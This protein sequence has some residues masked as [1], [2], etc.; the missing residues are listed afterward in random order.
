MIHVATFKGLLLNIVCGGVAVDLDIDLDLHQ[1]PFARYNYNN[2][3]K[4]NKT[5]RLMQIIFP[6]LYIVLIMVKRL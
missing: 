3:T 5:N 2:N 4:F 1:Q 6:Q